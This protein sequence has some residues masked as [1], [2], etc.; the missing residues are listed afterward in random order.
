M[1]ESN[2]LSKHLE[3]AFLTK[4]IISE[5]GLPCGKKTQGYF[6]TNQLRALLLFIK[7]TKEKSCGRQPVESSKPQGI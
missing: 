4:C 2:L 6:T 3:R 1:I 7:V 5:A